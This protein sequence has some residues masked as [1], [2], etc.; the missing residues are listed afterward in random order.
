MFPAVPLAKARKAR[1]Q[2][3]ELLAQGTD[4]S[5]HKQERKLAQRL[6]VG[7]S[8]EAVARSWFEH[9]SGPRSQRHADYV[10]RRLEADVFPVIG[11]K[12]IG[13][14]TYYDHWGSKRA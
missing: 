13:E 8:F 5:A 7:T 1:D 14:V 12:P 4:P 9:W 3:R 11:H 10:L 6:A 2:A